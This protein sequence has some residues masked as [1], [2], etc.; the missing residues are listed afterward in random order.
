MSHGDGQHYYKEID[1]TEHTI[2]GIH[3]ITG[4]WPLDAGRN[5]VIFIHGSGNSRLLW[6]GQVEGL[7][8]EINTVALDLPGHGKSAGLGMN[9]ITGYA[10]AVEKLIDEADIPGP[11]PCGLSMGGAVVLRMLLDSPSRYRAGILVN[12]G[13]RLRVLPAIF[14]AVRNN[15]EG[16][17]ASL[18]SVAA[19]PK[20]DTA[21]LKDIIDDAKTCSPEVVLGDF[22]ACDNFDVMDRLHEIKVPVL[23]LTA[24]DD[25]LSPVKYGRYLAEHIENAVY[26]E[27]PAAGHMSPVEKT[28]EVNRELKRFLNES[29]LQIIGQ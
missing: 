15:Y 24:E 27:I 14:D 2:G 21:L 20:T 25:R 16:Y 7:A 26:V 6:K 18:A 8:E 1:M 11:V 19:S 28:E 22:T 10:S 17:T 29:G 4:N 5:T 9:T 3:F 13:A 23:V 12:T